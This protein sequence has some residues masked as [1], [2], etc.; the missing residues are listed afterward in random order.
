MRSLRLVGYQILDEQR[1][2]WRNRIAAFFTF[3]FPVVLL[4]IFGSLNRQTRI[5]TLGPG[6]LAYAQYYV[7]SMVTFGIMSAC[8]V[9]VGTVLTIRRQTGLLKRVRSAPLSPGI[10][11]AGVIGNALVL[12]AM[13]TTVILTVGVAV[14]DVH[15]P[16]HWAATV[17]TLAL[18]TATFCGLGAAAT[19]L[20]R[21][22]SPE[23]AGGVLNGVFMPIAFISGAFFPVAK[24]S[25]LN[26]VAGF[27]PVRHFITATFAGF[28]PRHHTTALNSADL[29]VLICWGI[30][31]TLLALRRFQW[32]PMHN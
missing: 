3:A 2:F 30:A 15:L 23:G 22:T 18:G 9:N 7:P 5:T 14:F 32:Q 28:D 13:V 4:L 20:T 16:A 8:F 10:Y 1:S 17:L 31:G 19:L 25:V 6:Q 27:F 21:S 26:Q 29:A 11:L 24:D 12:A